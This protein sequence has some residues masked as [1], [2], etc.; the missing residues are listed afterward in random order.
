MANNTWEAYLWEV[1]DRVGGISEQLL[2][3]LSSLKR[4][5]RQKAF[6]ILS[7]D[8][9]DDINLFQTA[10]IWFLQNQ[11]TDAALSFLI[12]AF[13]Q[14]KQI[15]FQVFNQVYWATLWDLEFFLFEGKQEQ[16]SRISKKLD[17]LF[18]GAIHQENYRE[19]DDFLCV[20]YDE[21]MRLQDF[22]QAHLIAEKLIQRNHSLW[23]LFL[24]MMY[25]H[26]NNPQKTMD[27]FLIGW[28]HHKTQIYLEHIIRFSY[29]IWDLANAQKYY[30]I[31]VEIFP[32]MG[33]FIEY[34]QKITSWEEFEIFIEKIFPHF[35]S[36]AIKTLLESTI[37]FLQ[38]QLAYE[39][40]QFQ[41]SKDLDLITSQQALSQILKIGYY[42]SMY[43]QN[44]Q[45]FLF[46]VYQLKAIW[47]S[48]DPDLCKVLEEFLEEY[49]HVELEFQSLLWDDGDL[50]MDTWN[51]EKNQTSSMQFQTSSSDTKI[52]QTVSVEMHL[53]LYIQSQGRSFIS[54]ENQWIFTQGIF[55]F[56][57][58][59]VK[60]IPEHE[61][62][63]N[64]ES[65]LIYVQ[66]Y[67]EK[68]A[69]IF[70][71]F[72]P[73]MKDTYDEFIHEIDSKFGL[74]FRRNTQ[75]LA[76]NFE[77]PE[78]LNNAELVILHCI[79]F[80]VAKYISSWLSSEQIWE[81]L[82]NYNI[83]SL[84]LSDTH[85]NLLWEVLSLF[86]DYESAMKVFVYTH[87]QFQDEISLYNILKTK[88][89]IPYEK[90]VIFEQEII[91]NCKI[92]GSLDE[93]MRQCI[94][95]IEDSHLRLLFLWNYHMVFPKS[96]Q[97]FYKSQKAFQKS[98]DSWDIEW[99]LWLARLLE[100]VQDFS[101]ALWYYETA[102]WEQPTNPKYL[103][104]CLR[105]A[106]TIDDKQKVE[107]FIKKISL[108]W[109]R[110]FETEYFTYLW[111][112]KRNFLAS[113]YYI[114]SIHKDIPIDIS[115]F[116]MFDNIYEV[117]TQ[118]TWYMPNKYQEKIWAQIVLLLHSNFD[119]SYQLLFLSTLLE[120]PDDY[121]IEFAS[122]AFGLIYDNYTT[123]ENNEILLEQVQMFAQ[124]IAHNE[125][126]DTEILPMIR[127]FYYYM[128]KLLQ[129]IPGWEK[130]AQEYM[131]KL[132]IPYLEWN[133]CVLPNELSST[134]YH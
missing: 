55:P 89:Y 12:A 19:N 6:C 109:Y 14:W 112:Y 88:C 107:N 13:E 17:L 80:L 3:R 23:Y 20:L 72:P 101:W 45:V 39:Q 67:I 60:Q 5:V 108:F 11:D 62:K 40:E 37:T 54:H 116:G 129:K 85:L 18:A 41:K 84:P 127:D 122:R 69:N 87:S 79:E 58:S 125:I 82:K 131:K 10:P 47:E 118:D 77:V 128:I 111:N 44:P 106:F 22:E 42:L 53:Y 123:W 114:S 32:K 31:W 74:F 59:L 99:V 78:T 15:D 133:F 86:E 76:K 91:D 36:D 30:Q 124:E 61:P 98:M 27:S 96:N 68:E 134:L 33:Y 64:I 9:G 100:S 83:F 130:Q 117:A 119:I 120:I 103:K 81:I 95:D 34:S 2:D 94:N 26:Q 105:V 63:E 75:W 71:Q 28:E 56:L 73:S 29:Q 115:C 35:S 90:F 57:N 48:Q 1:A 50:S 38:E 25:S 4:N 66:D 110:W 24:W 65:I 43:T 51:I 132:D 16:V 93:Y 70:A 49:S 104:E 97:D 121:C 21:K 102:Y 8:F 126:Q 113:D 92:S 7:Q 52:Q 46:H